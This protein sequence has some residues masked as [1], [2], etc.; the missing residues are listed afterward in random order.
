MDAQEV[1]GTGSDRDEGMTSRETLEAFMA[2]VMIRDWDHAATLCTKTQQTRD[3]ILWW[4]F[5]HLA[6]DDFDLEA[7]AS[8]TPCV[9]DW[10]VT[11]RVDGMIL[12]TGRVR[13]IREDAAYS[14]S[15]T[16]A[17]G[18]NPESWR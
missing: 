13:L 8:P 4:R 15:E 9:E 17:W 10:R 18:V 6:F 12:K 2:A 14:P 16:G 1:R 7:E 3:K 5:D 11:L